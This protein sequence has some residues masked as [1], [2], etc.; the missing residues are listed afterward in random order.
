MR[1]IKAPF[2]RLCSPGLGRKPDL[3]APALYR[4]ARSTGSALARFGLWFVREAAEVADEAHEVKQSTSLGARTALTLDRDW[5]S[6]RL[7]PKLNR[8]Q[9]LIQSAI[10]TARL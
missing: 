10:F 1:R 9:G 5:A 4:D 6:S 2:A 7:V 8:F 3:P